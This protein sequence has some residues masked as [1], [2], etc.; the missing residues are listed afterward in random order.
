MRNGI[1]GNTKGEGNV[2]VKLNKNFMKIFIPIVLILFTACGQ[3]KKN[4]FADKNNIR[5]DSIK[6]VYL[7]K[8]SI[9]L[10]SV[11]LTDEQIKSFVEK[12]NHS[13]SLG[14]Y[15]YL[16]QY[17]IFITMK[18]GSIRKFRSSKDKIKESNDWTFSLQDSSFIESCWN[19][20][21]YPFSIPD[22][23]DPIRFIETISKKVKTDNGSFY[24]GFTMV[25]N[26]PIDWVKKENIDTLI[27]LL[28]SRDSCNCFID[29]LS[30]YIPNDFAEK[31]G[32]ATVFIKSYKDKK[33][34][35][36][37]LYSCPKADR[38]MEKELINWWKNEK[39]K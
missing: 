37:G 35:K 21:N 23:Y 30:S 28:S 34:I 31:G 26:F 22:N 1:Q 39:D 20:S 3:I 8:S 36:F 4:S 2:M 29:P 15:K 7:K 9:G 33:P 10:D 12:W 38:I 18:S 5:I 24:L 14:P 17:W 11:R 19:K 6:S 16:P 13:K 32:Y 25:D 27:S